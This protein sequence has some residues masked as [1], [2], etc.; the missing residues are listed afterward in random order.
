MQLVGVDPGHNVAGGLRLSCGDGCF[1][2]NAG[3]KRFFLDVPVVAREIDGLIGCV[4]DR[5][6]ETRFFP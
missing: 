6:Y 2:Q 5:K 3:V 1:Q 4:L